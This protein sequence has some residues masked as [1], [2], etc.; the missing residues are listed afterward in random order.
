[1]S[2]RESDQRD[3]ELH[4]FLRQAI[5]RR[6]FLRR[7]ALGAGGL[8][9]S[10]EQPAR[11]VRRRQ[12]GRASGGRRLA[13]AAA[14]AE[15]QDA[16]HLQLAALHRQADRAR[17]REGHGHQDRVH[18]GHQRQ[19]RVLRQD[20]RAAQAEPEHRP[21]HHRAHR[22]DGG[23]HDQSRLRGPARR[24]QVPQQGEPGRQRE[25]RELRS[26]PQVQRAVAVGHDRR[27]LQ[28]EEDRPRA[29]QH[30]R[31]LRP[32]VQGPGH[33]ADRDAGHPRPGD[34]GHG[35]GSRQGHQG[36]R[37]GRRGQDQEGARERPDPEVHRQR[38]RR[39]PGGGQHR[40]RVRLV[41]RH[42]G[43]GG[44]Q[45]GPPV[46]R[47]QGRRHAVLRQHDDPQ[48]LRPAGPG[49]GLDQLRLRSQALGPDRGRRA[50]PVGRQGHRRRS[51]PRSRPSWPT[52]RWSTRPTTSARG[53]TC[54]G[55]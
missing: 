6:G 52:A 9:P 11:R 49:D 43:A 34:A 48:D 2:R 28:P 17:L 21:R 22:L 55:R 54:S 13:A 10:A 31:H 27:R 32:Q 19:R 39:G 45:P 15:R 46:D 47:A 33:D 16:P 41:G 5:T 29:H 44:R 25:G 40:D 24:R 42:P 36:R 38:L 4:E 53:C 26:G 7:S 30:Q 50:L 3:A 37:R 12:G 18:R 8:M 14:P 23:P 35:Q 51:W 20:R 1:M